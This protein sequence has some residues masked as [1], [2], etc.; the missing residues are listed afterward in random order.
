LGADGDSVRVSAMCLE[1]RLAPSLFDG[2][3][4]NSVPQYTSINGA[5]MPDVHQLD[6]RVDKRWDF[7][8]WAL[9]LY[10]DV[11]NVYNHRIVDYYEYN[12]DYTRRAAV[13]GLPLLPNLGIKGEI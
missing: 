1:I 12:W 5:R 2:Q 7:R 11:R 3:T 10:L 6:L 8:H 13:Q 4:G 9:T